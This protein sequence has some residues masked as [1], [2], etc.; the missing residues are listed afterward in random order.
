M[1][2]WGGRFTSS[3]APSAEAFGASISFDCRLWPFDLMGSAAHCRMLAHTNILTPR[4]AQSILDGL[5][6]VANEL[7]A[8]QLDLSEKWEDIHTRVESRLGELIGAAAG[9]LH[10][11]RSRN[12]Q[13]ALDVRLF[14]RAAIADEIDALIGIQRAFLDLAG[15]N[16]EV[17]M[18]G[19]T[20]LQHAQPVLFSHH[21]LAYVEMFDRD[22]ARLLDCHERTD[23]LPLGSGALAGVPYPIDRQMTARL[24]GFSRISLN[25]IDAVSDR[26]FVAEHLAALA[27]IA[28]HLSRLAEELVL[29]S[30]AEFG[31]VTIDEGYT[32]GSSIMPQ[33]RNP[34]LAELVRG[35]TGRVFGHLFS[36]LT[37]LKGQPL[38][39]N[40]DLQEDK[41]AFF[42][43]VDTITASLGIMKEMVQGLQVHVETT[44]PSAVSQFALATDYADYLA[45]KGLPF[46]EA[47]GIVGQLVKTCEADGRRLEDLS[48]E[49]L[50][51]ISPLFES[52][53]VSL[54]AHDA[55][56]ARQVP[57]GT[58]PDQ[59]R[60][61]HTA[62]HSRLAERTAQLARLRAGFP[63]LETLLTRPLDVT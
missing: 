3:A 24:L 1:K 5:G 20:H 49:D 50:Q 59:V 2:Q 11:A 54:S 46:R 29:W 55:V 30:T 62:A 51:A 26:D 8:G 60:S 19:F 10:T 6:I 32:T 53:A 34:D 40:K 16:M 21:M 13:V 25:S 52:D 22:A 57:G 47:H 44:G 58:A 9:R 31:F 42:D 23:V 45:K 56:A 41:E 12:D 33:K 28:M 18:P 14:A 61:A 37:T 4:D 27:L 38:A 36:L 48:L 43:S 35:K 39:Y 15:S 7:A 63:S 17:L